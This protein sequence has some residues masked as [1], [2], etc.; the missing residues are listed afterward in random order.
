M[1]LRYAWPETDVVVLAFVAGIAMLA[2]GAAATLA[3]SVF[4]VLSDSASLGMWCGIFATL[5][6]TQV[7]V[8]AWFIP[9]F[10]RWY[11]TD[12][13]SENRFKM[14]HVLRHSC[15]VKINMTQKISSKRGIFSSFTPFTI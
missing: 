7:A 12:V 5:A 4:S 11:V 8:G 15:P 3:T 9:I 1:T 10:P 2:A 13:T 6:A 14:G